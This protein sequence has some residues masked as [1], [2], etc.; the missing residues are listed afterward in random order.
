MTRILSFCPPTT[1]RTKRINKQR[2]TGR[3]VRTGEGNDQ[4]HR[5][6]GRQSE[7]VGSTDAVEQA[8]NETRESKRS[9]KPDHDSCRAQLRPLTNNDS[10]DIERL[11]TEYCSDTELI[12]SLSYGIRH[13]AIYSDRAQNKRD[14]CKKAE[15]QGCEAPR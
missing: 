14:R 9:Y 3:D 8:G 10:S 12:P 13:H 11:R 1:E 2:R 6:N 5:S 4:E 7:W 15:E